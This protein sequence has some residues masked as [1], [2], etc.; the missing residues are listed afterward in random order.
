MA[1][2]LISAI[3][4][5]QK[6]YVVTRPFNGD[7]DYRFVRG[8]VV[9]TTGWTHHKRLVELRYLQPLPHGAPVPSED[10]DG[11]RILEVADDGSV[12]EKKKPAKRAVKKAAGKTKADR[13]P[14]I[15][16]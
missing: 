11:R 16:S 9:D 13:V 1:D 5:E 10:A 4:P 6:W 12:P 15:R 7:G 8:E 3:T 2:P 14:P